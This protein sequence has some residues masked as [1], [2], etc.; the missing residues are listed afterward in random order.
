MQIHDLD[1][2]LGREISA[3]RSA[4]LETEEIAAKLVAANSEVDYLKTKF[5]E[6]ETLC[7]QL[8]EMKLQM[9]LEVTD[10]TSKLKCTEEE[11][12]RRRSTAEALREELEDEVK[13]NKEL[14]SNL[15]RKSRALEEAYNDLSLLQ[16]EK[17]TTDGV[18][19]DLQAQVES[20][21]R[22][23]EEMKAAHQDT[24]EEHDRIVLRVCSAERVEADVRVKLD[25]ETARGVHLEQQLYAEAQK[26]AGLAASVEEFEGTIRMVLQRVDKF[27]ASTERTVAHYK[28]QYAALHQK[29]ADTIAGAAKSESEN[30]R[31]AA[32]LRQANQ[33]SQSL[34]V[35]LRQVLE[36][37]AKFGEAFQERTLRDQKNF[38]T[39]FEE[40]CMAIDPSV[41]RA[42][43]LTPAPSIAF[44]CRNSKENCSEGEENEEVKHVERHEEE[45]ESDA[46]WKVL[47]YVAGGDTSLVEAL[48]VQEPTSWSE[49]GVAARERAI[50]I[51]DELTQLKASE[52][53]LNHNLQAR[54]EE[55]EVLSVSLEKVQRDLIASEVREKDQIRRADDLSKDL[56]ALKEE[57]KL[58]NSRL[59]E[60]LNKNA[61][62]ETVVDASCKDQLLLKMQWD[63]AKQ[64]LE[65]A[66]ARVEELQE[67]HRNDGK[68]K[69]TLQLAVDAK[70][71]RLQQLE[72]DLTQCQLQLKDAKNEKDAAVREVE[73]H[74]SD[75]FQALSQLAESKNALK[76]SAEEKLSQ[77]QRHEDSIAHKNEMIEGLRQELAAARQEIVAAREGQDQ[78]RVEVNSL[79]NERETLRT[80]LADLKLQL[81]MTLD[82]EVVLKD[83][84]LENEGRGA[85]LLQAKKQRIELLLEEVQVAEHASVVAEAETEKIKLELKKQV[86]LLEDE[87][88]KS[89]DLRSAVEQATLREERLVA[90][91]DHLKRLHED[92]L[93]TIT[94]R[95]EQIKKLEDQLFAVTKRM[96]EVHLKHENVEATWTEMKKNAE[97]Q[98]AEKVKRLEHLTDMNKKMYAAI[99]GEDVPDFL[100]YTEVSDNFYHHSELA[101]NKAMSHAVQLRTNFKNARTQVESIQRSILNQDDY[102]SDKIRQYEDQIWALTVQIKE[103]QDEKQEQSGPDEWSTKRIEMLEEEVRFKSEQLASSESR[104]AAATQELCDQH[105]QNLQQVQQQTKQQHGEVDTVLD[106]CLL[107]ADLVLQTI[108]HMQTALYHTHKR[109]QATQQ[110]L[111]QAA[112]EQLYKEGD[113]I[114]RL[115][116]QVRTRMIKSG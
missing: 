97:A 104:L 63:E 30:R 29:S 66:K 57:Q 79:E 44:S 34:E 103:L 9:Q 15:Q 82:R 78:L 47:G 92:D 6:T 45:K 23:L 56:V 37:S 55:V 4:E 76:I 100:E 99:C 52:Q 68:H 69:L 72:Q 51:N 83:Q 80:E 60:G 102:K 17:K 116:G 49:I 106:K 8:Q 98:L 22:A 61:E 111:R 115:M 20:S 25:R 53:Q 36:D 75:A 67:Q 86:E 10:C 96:H 46:Q 48:C 113:I 5:H 2:R 35:S 40:L 64:E 42:S 90:R 112:Y 32:E 114:S 27:R 85:E 107:G 109:A 50:Q 18:M 108:M 84:I 81:T 110:S 89:H 62:L 74:K 95:D 14:Q 19:S 59:M 39:I 24:K 70:D 13:R 105:E 38:E 58:L 91:S 101:S 1:E 71:S 43:S 31:L 28:S 7:S 93:R 87:R 41:S 21:N 11:N 3:R 94:Q 33:R 54:E 77:Q 65:D 12:V 16:H 73:H 26:V 88:G